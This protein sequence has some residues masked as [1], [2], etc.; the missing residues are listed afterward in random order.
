MQPEMRKEYCQFM[1]GV[2]TADQQNGAHAHDHKACNNHWRRVIDKKI[3]QS[4]TNGFLC[5]RKWGS[6]LKSEAE[7]RVESGEGETAANEKLGRAIVEL[8][9]LAKLERADWDTVLARELQARCNVGSTHAGGRRAQAKAKAKPSTE[10]GRVWGSVRVKAARYCMNPDC[11]K[12][13]QN[14]C[15]CAECTAGGAQGTLMCRACFMDAASHT[16]AAV[17]RVQGAKG[18]R[19]RKDMGWIKHSE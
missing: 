1:G 19:R 7:G 18:T 2:D 13:S 15:S 16:A 12:R 17:A 4:K 11:S 14:G 8:D 3:E 5:F 9:R 6:E 10:E